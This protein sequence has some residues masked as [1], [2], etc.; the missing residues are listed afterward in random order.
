[1]TDT[2]TEIPVIIAVCCREWPLAAGIPWGYCGECGD[3]PVVIRA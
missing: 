3:K 1:M 2:M